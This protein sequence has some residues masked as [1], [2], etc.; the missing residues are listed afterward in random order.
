M[1]MLLVVVGMAAVTYIPRMLPAVF[2]HRLKLPRWL[3]LW[4]RTVPYAALGA[5]IFPGIMGV[6]PQ[7]PAVGLL[8]GLAAAVLAFFRLHLV[9]V[10][11]AAIGTVLLAGHLLV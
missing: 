9:L 5:L 6:V 10:M 8:G 11:A 2:M 3:Q 1:K 7:E 4:L